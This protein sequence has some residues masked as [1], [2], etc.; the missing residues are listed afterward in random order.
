MLVILTLSAM[1]LGL[2]IDGYKAALMFGLLTAVISL[3]VFF[4]RKF[5]T[6]NDE[7][8]RLRNVLAKD[9]EKRHQKNQGS[10]TEKPEDVTSVVDASS[11]FSQEDRQP[12]GRAVVMASQNAAELKKRQLLM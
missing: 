9:W 11:P 2:L 12:E 1:L 3:Y 8:T 6:L 4:N 7:I 10:E 5:T